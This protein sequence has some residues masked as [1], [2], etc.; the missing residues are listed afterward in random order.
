ML[1][2]D[3]VVIIRTKHA[4]E[5]KSERE[6]IYIH[7]DFVYVMGPDTVLL[8]SCRFTCISPVLC[9]DNVFHGQY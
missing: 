6:T 8:H 9:Q 4:S 7:T 5:K 2:R 1:I 3:D